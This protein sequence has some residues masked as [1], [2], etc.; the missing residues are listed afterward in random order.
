MFKLFS[1]LSLLVDFRRRDVEAVDLQLITD[2]VDGSNH[3]VEENHTGDGEH[4]CEEV[5]FRD[6]ETGL[7]LHHYVEREYQEE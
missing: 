4:S 6:F 7:N 3:P 5:F 1:V 2:L